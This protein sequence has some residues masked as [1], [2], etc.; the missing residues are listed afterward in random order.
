MGRSTV[1]GHHGGAGAIAK[2]SLHHYSVRFPKAAQLDAALLAALA[3]MVE[4]RLAHFNAQI[5]CIQHTDHYVEHVDTTLHVRVRCVAFSVRQQIQS[6]MYYRRLRLRAPRCREDFR[7]RGPQPPWAPWVP[8][9]PWPPW[10]PWAP[11]ALGPKIFW[12]PG[13]QQHGFLGVA[14][15]WKSSS[16]KVI[17]PMGPVGPMGPHGDP[18]D[19]WAHGDP[20]GTHGDPWGPMGP[21]GP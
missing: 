10:G 9:G 19:P 6:A 17:W 11:R 14:R 7:Q 3:R 12:V 21:M 16:D 1:A 15:G 4:R 2:Y 8:L 18:W 20:W 5:F 13:P